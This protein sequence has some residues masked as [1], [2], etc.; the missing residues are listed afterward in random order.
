MSDGNRIVRTHPLPESR[1]SHER[2][3]RISECNKRLLSENQTLRTENQKLLE[4]N[5]KLKDGATGLGFLV[6]SLQAE[7]KSLK[8]KE[9]TSDK[10]I[11]VGIAV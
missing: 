1:S 7:I 9:E 10:G 4:E 2:M 5:K 6:A 8:Q 3:R 11:D